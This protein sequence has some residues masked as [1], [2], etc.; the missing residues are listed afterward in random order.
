MGTEGSME[1]TV[2]PCYQPFYEDWRYKVALGGRSA[3][4]SVAAA[5]AIV[6]FCSQAKMRVLYLREFQNSIEESCK[7]QVEAIIEDLGLAHEWKFTI[8]QTTHRRTGSVIMYEGLARNYT[9]IKSKTDIDIAAI[10]ECETVSRDSLD[11]LIPT[12]RRQG[13]ELWFMGNPKDRTSAVAQLFIENGTP[14]NCVVMRST[15]LDNP[16][17]S[18]ELIAEANHLMATDYKLYRHI[19]LGEY[20][21]KGSLRMVPYVVEEDATTV[22]AASDAVVI[23][24]DIAR[25]GDDKTALCVRKGKKILLLESHSDMDLP[26]LVAELTD[27]IRRYKPAR[28]N[29]DS[30][31]HGAWAKDGLQSMGVTVSEVN[32]SSKAAKED[33]YTNKR[34][35]LYG[36]A[37][38][39]FEG[40]GTI[41][42]GQ[43]QLVEE[44][45]STWYNLDNKNRFALESKA[46]I[47]KRI[48]RSPDKADSL[49]L[50]LWNPQGGIF[51][52]A[53]AATT[54]MDSRRFTNDLLNAGSYGGKWK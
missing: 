51:A 1:L 41:P 18:A 29:I 46:D 38:D 13:S 2:L 36:L 37:R 4:R 7:A 34:T 16:F 9:K 8:K 28:I 3:G 5:Q 33:K 26:K 45:E 31:G 21:D 25:E 20:L 30:T 40:G 17:N 14:A 12:I 49:C 24:C 10:E 15:Y 32:F 39:Y 50:S 43:T 42:K 22:P 44:L 6:Y 48:G 52:K 35:E 11:I 23:G 53:V 19:Y 27:L 47:K 54:T